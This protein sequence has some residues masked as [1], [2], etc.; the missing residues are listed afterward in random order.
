[1]QI[2]KRIPMRKLLFL[3]I[4]GFALASCQQ[5]PKSL[6][7]QLEALPSATVDSAEVDTT[8][9]SE[10]YDLYFTQK[11]DHFDPGS[12]EFKQRVLVG[13]AGFD[14]PTVVVL[15][16]YSIY[17]GRVTELAKLLNANQV[18]IEHRFFKDSRP[19]SI[20]W[21][22]LNIRQAAADQHKIIKALKTIYPGKWISTGISKGGQTTVY[23]RR[24]YP[25]DVDV[26]VPYV[27]PINTSDEE[28]A[29]YEFLENVGTA[30]CR[31]KIR[32]FQH[33]LFQKKDQILPLLKDYAEEKG[34]TFRMGI[35]KAYNYNVM[36][37]EFA[38]WQWGQ[39]CD[40]IPEKGSNP[41]T[42][43]KHWIGTAPIDFFAEEG[44]DPI[45]PFFYQA[46]TEIGMYGYDITPFKQ[47]LD[48]TINITFDFT[49]PEGVDY[50]FKPEV[51]ED[52]HR[53]LRDSSR[54][55]LF[56]YGEYD[57]WSASAVEPSG[58][59]NIKVF[60]NPWG[61][62][63][64]RIRHFP[65]EMQ[66]SIVSTLESWLDMEIEGFVKKEV[67]DTSGGSSSQEE[68]NIPF[69]IL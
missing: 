7:T 11:T 54:N 3:M 32:D 24:F 46:M 12:P 19:D 62:H 18:V 45:R 44:I 20:P 1:M 67:P 15:E 49:S 8:L 52:I 57:A 47:Y 40:N 16:G 43:F 10:A 58:K 22:K 61:N 42:M 33:R 17:S 51:L 5:A 69:Q 29:V 48:D 30:A 53:W 36:E 68:A 65:P 59:T 21:D 2:T 13:H 37:Y 60:T 4:L 31:E 6:K 23:H 35:E 28:P 41:E 27:A 64:T 25:Q 50:T 63:T 14:R 26:S 9:F 55:M 38:F 56:I 66:D 34:Y 39:L